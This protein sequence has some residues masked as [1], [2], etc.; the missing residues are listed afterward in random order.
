MQCPNTAVL[1]EPRADV[2]SIRVPANGATSFSHATDFFRRPF[3]DM[4][5]IIVDCEEV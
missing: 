1:Q 4:P 5:Q 2:A 3:L